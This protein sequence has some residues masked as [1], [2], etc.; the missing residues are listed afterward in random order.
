MLSCSCDFDYDGEGWYWDNQQL[1]PMPT[2]PRR[3]RCG[4]CKELINPG[5]EVFRYT[6]KRDATEFESI[7]FNWDEVV[8]PP[9]YTCEECSDLISAVSDLGFCWEWGDSIKDQIAQYRWASGSTTL[10]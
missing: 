9:W 5:E 10:N 3:R 2:F 6:R 1:M 7:R 4:C 8:L